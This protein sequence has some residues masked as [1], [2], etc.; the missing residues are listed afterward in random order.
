MRERI[1][2]D[3]EKD[4]QERSQLTS[5]CDVEFEVFLRDIPFGLTRVV[6]FLQMR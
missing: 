1:E 3:L 2:E 6:I 5:D 4:E